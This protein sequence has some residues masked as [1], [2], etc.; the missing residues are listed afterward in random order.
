MLTPTFQ[1]VSLAYVACLLGY[2]MMATSVPIINQ[3][4]GKSFDFH[5]QE[6]GKPTLNNT[7]PSKKHN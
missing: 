4:F 7:K 6:D 1:S 5:D 2:V 3:V